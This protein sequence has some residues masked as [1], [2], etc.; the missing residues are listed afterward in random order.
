MS[1]DLAAGTG[2]GQRILQCGFSKKLQTQGARC[3]HVLP[4]YL[5]GG[6]AVLSFD[7]LD[8]GLVFVQGFGPAV[9]C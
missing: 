4:G 3:F 1:V 9:S 7:G 6:I 2:V 8:Q 5:S